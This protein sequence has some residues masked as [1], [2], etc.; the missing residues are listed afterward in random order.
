MSHVFPGAFFHAWRPMGGTTCD[1]GG[2]VRPRDT[3]IADGEAE[4]SNATLWVF[5]VS[6][7]CD[8]VLRGS[9]AFATCAVVYMVCA[10]LGVALLHL[11]SLTGVSGHVVSTGRYVA[12]FRCGVGL[13]RLRSMQGN[14]FGVLLNPRHSLIQ[15]IVPR[16]VD[17]P[18]PVPQRHGV[19]P[20]AC[21]A[22]VRHAVRSQGP[23]MTRPSGCGSHCC[24]T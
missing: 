3:P 10:T 19:R 4:S 12:I 23:P 1:D 14:F 21:P 5:K 2:T 8:G 13:V 11:Q 9:V 18:I 6:V 22:Q 15:C 24:Q 16:A 20:S 17:I 7:N